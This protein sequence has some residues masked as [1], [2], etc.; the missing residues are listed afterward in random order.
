MNDLLFSKIMAYYEKKKTDDE[1]VCPDCGK[2]ASDCVC[3]DEGKKKKSDKEVKESLELVNDAL[4]IMLEASENAS[5]A[6]EEHKIPSVAEASKSYKKALKDNDFTKAIQ[7]VNEMEAAVKKFD[8][9]TSSLKD[10]GEIKK[11]LNQII[12]TNDI[13]TV[14]VGA[15]ILGN[16]NITDEKRI[17]MIS[18]LIQALKDST[19]KI[20]RE[21]KSDDIKQLKV[22]LKAD[23][24]IVYKVLVVIKGNV[25]IISKLKDAAD[26]K[27]K[28][29]KSKVV[30]ESVDK[31]YNKFKAA[32]YESCANGEITLE[33]REELLNNL[34]DKKYLSE[35]SEYEIYNESLDKKDK[36][37]AIKHALYERCANGEL[38][39]EQRE[40]L[41][42]KAKEMIFESSTEEPTKVN[43]NNDPDKLMK[44]VEKSTG[45]EMDKA[46]E[47]LKS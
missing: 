6:K 24:G 40:T 41:I 22:A 26:K 46:V 17:E 23:L 20:R 34:K 1:P 3:E 14:S 38:T 15:G 13:M 30:K 32:L 21:S 10:V 42:C 36:F 39:V 9:D 5:E 4:N 29:E 44:D 11:A 47:N 37:N 45:K 12:V 19:D 28:V 7:S 27:D 43:K 35:A 16:K 31:V 8:K 2:P 33:E 25:N 18:K